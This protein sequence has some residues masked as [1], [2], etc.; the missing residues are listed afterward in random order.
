MQFLSMAL[1]VLVGNAVWTIVLV[2]YTTY[3]ARQSNAGFEDAMHQFEQ[4][5]AAREAKG[6]DQDS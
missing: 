6:G 2:S 3:R 4:A 5:L 1:A